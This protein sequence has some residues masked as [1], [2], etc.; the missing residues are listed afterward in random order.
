MQ[1]E[2]VFVA[3]CTAV[4][5]AA[6]RSKTLMHEGLECERGLYGRC[7]FPRTYEKG[8][9]RK[10]GDMRSLRAFGASRGLTPQPKRPQPKRNMTDVRVRR[11]L[12][13]CCQ[14]R[15]NGEAK[16]F[17][18]RAVRAEADNEYDPEMDAM[19]RMQ[20]S[21]TACESELMGIRTGV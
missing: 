8:F 17:A 12:F 18:T 20:K 4:P 7:T 21:V 10:V 6:T 11:A 16:R 19:D 15:H 2:L 14:L 1:S 5:G 13:S 3:A 9:W